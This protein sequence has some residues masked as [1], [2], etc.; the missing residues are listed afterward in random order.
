MEAGPPRRGGV[1]AVNSEIAEI[2]IEEE[3]AIS[4]TL[5]MNRRK[6]ESLQTSARPAQSD[7]AHFRLA[8][9]ACHV[10]ATPYSRSD[11]S[12][13]RADLRTAIAANPH[14]W[15]FADNVDSQH[16]RRL[17]MLWTAPT[18]QHQSAIGWLRIANHLRG[19]V[20]GRD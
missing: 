8:V 6:S 13:P 19:A 5:L 10:T 14:L 2:G 12:W 7:H 15:S 9:E 16:G 11:C 4:R 3:N 17:L 20:H 1:D 18:P